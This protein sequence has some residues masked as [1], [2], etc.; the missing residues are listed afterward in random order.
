MRNAF[1]IIHR[2]AGLFIAVFLLIAGLTGALIS[3]DHELDEAL[4]PHLFH[5]KSTGG[6]SI[7]PLALAKKIEEADPRVRATFFPL[8]IEEGHNFEAF[9]QPR[10]DPKTGELYSVDYNQVFLDP[11]TGEVAGKRFWGA[12]SLDSENIL[13]FLYKLHYSMHIPDMWNIE[14]GMW[15]MGLVGIVWLFDCFVG[16]YLTLPRRRRGSAAAAVAT[17]AKHAESPQAGT[18]QSWWQRWKPAWKIKRGASTY[19]LNLDLHRAFGLWLWLMLFILA[20]TSISMNLN[21][22]VVRPI[23]STVST[24]TPDAFDDV[25]GTPLNKPIEPKL[26][27]AEAIK[28][29]GREMQRQGWNEPPGS[30]FYGTQHGLYAVS[31]YRP[32]DDHNTMAMKML[33]VDASDGSFKGGRI[34]WEGTAADIFMQLQFP[35]HSGRIAGIPGRVFLSFMGLVVALLS[36]TGIVIWFK[37]RAARQSAAASRTRDRGYGSS[38]PNNI[39]AE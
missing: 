35:L 36:I 3:W 26:N 29:A 28:A 37:K 21:D 33:F 10:V 22:E 15:F 18:S 38:A 5:A 27:F 13:P 2:W 32:E 6:P 12:I 11:V 1:V 14:I 19:R 23:L 31:F 8:A 20:F 16:F 34:P 30:V 7:D 9:V 4:N 24:L 25:A 39:P 17:G